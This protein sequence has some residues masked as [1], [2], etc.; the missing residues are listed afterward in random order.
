[1][2]STYVIELLLQERGNLQLGGQLATVNVELLTVTLPS[3]AVMT[4]VRL[5]APFD[6]TLEL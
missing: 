5:C 3:V 2:S 6:S 1:L 4:A